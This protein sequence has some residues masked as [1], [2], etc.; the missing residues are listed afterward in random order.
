VTDAPAGRAPCTAVGPLTLSSTNPNC[1]DGDAA[2]GIF[3]SGLGDDANPG[4]MAFPKRTIAAGLIAAGQQ[5][6]N[7]VYVTKGVFPETLD[8]VNGVNLYGGYDAA[9]QRSPANV[10]KITGPPGVP[11]DV[12]AAV[13]NGVTKPTEL[14]LLTLAPSAPT[15]L[16]ASSYGLQGKDSGRLVLDHV[17]VTAAPGAT[18]APGLNGSPGAPGGDGSSPPTE[19]SGRGGQSAVGHLGGAGGVGGF[20]GHAG[21][22][23]SPGQA[24]TPDAWGHMGGPGGSGGAGDSAYRGGNGYDGDTGLF[25]GDGFGDRTGSVCD[26]VWCSGSGE[27]GFS[28]SAGHGGGGGGGGGSKSCHID[29]SENSGG[30]A[31]AVVAAARAEPGA[32]AVRAAVARSASWW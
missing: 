8:V 22:D 9:W 24:T 6:K 5:N 19:G 4:T 2:H 16:G 27:P 29:C 11:G 12:A 21:Y 10:T 13:A 23:G 17:T 31:A 32:T 28:G 1:F 30:G 20:G 25:E 26:A 3:V 15:S 18:G 14:Q 7:D